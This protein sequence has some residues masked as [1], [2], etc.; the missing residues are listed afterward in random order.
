MSRPRKTVVS[1]LVNNL[2]AKQKLLV[3]VSG[4]VDS[5]T[6]LHACVHL[7]SKLGLSLEV[8]HVDHRLRKESRADAEFVRR[9]AADY[10]VP[11]H[12]CVADPFPRGKNVE[13]WARQ[14]RYGFFQEVLNKRRLDAVLTAHT[15][16]DVAETFLMRLVSNKELKSIARFDRKR[17]C[18][19]PLVDV[20]R[21]EIEAYAKAHALKFVEDRTN[22]D[23]DY[24][25]N[26]VRH[27]LIP[28]LAR[29][30]DPRIVEVLSCRASGLADDLSFLDSLVEPASEKLSKSEFGSR[31]WLRALREELKSV[32]AVLKWRL[33]EALLKELLGFNLGRVRGAELVEFLE[34]GRA[35]IELPGHLRLRAHAGGIAVSRPGK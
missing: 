2:E 7:V 20:S 26:R 35:G 27:K 31:K 8:A 3:A 14:L 4:G 5:V 21:S 11:F 6:L 34:G 1:T 19:R 25:R 12:L 10:D 22:Y 28:V 30:F 18:I 17:K 29:E 9:L 24:L 16:N 32:P 23:T 15:A 13:A 33:A